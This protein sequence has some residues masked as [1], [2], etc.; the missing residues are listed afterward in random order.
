MKTMAILGA[1]LA[2][3]LSGGATAATTPAPDEAAWQQAVQR[4]MAAKAKRNKEPRSFVD[5]IL[6]LGEA[7]YAKRD[8]E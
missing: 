7:T 6:G 2:F 5:A 4:V 8:R 3:S 1:L